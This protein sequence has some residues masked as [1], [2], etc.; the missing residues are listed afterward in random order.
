MRLYKIFLFTL[1]FC[2][3]GCKPSDQDWLSYG[4]DL[5]NQRYA[6]ID[7]INYK[8]VGSLKLAWQHQTGIKATF[9]STPIVH[10]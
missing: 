2:L 8:N 5:T 10:E 4:K 3:M 7:E 1:I 6:V 9:Q